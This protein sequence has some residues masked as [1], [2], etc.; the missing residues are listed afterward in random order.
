MYCEDETILSSYTEARIPCLRYTPW[1]ANWS[2]SPWTRAIHTRSDLL[3]A[4]AAS[5]AESKVRIKRR[6]CP[7][8]HRTWAKAHESVISTTDQSCQSAVRAASS[9]CQTNSSRTWTRYERACLPRQQPGRT[10]T[11]VGIADGQPRPGSDVQLASPL[12]RENVPACERF[13]K[14]A[15]REIDKDDVVGGRL[16]LG[17]CATLGSLGEELARA[18]HL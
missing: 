17:D 14:L 8:R 10:K 6:A 7:G 9:S 18:F 16:N 3:L 15:L 2:V 11:M 12:D 13:L 1:V 5:L 4:D